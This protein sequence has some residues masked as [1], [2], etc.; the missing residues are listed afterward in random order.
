MAAGDVGKAVAAVRWA[1]RHASAA[2]RLTFTVCRISLARAL[3]TR[4]ARD[5]LR[6]YDVTVQ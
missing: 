2:G 3:P 5:M 6:F 4:L 1:P